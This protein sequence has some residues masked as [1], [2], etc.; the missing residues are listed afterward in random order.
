MRGTLPVA[1]LLA[2]TFL[3][4]NQLVADDPQKDAGTTLIPLL[5]SYARAQIDIT[6]QGNVLSGVSGKIDEV[7]IKTLDAEKCN[8]FL[9]AAQEAYEREG[10]ALLEADLK[11]LEQLEV[12]PEWTEIHA[13][14]MKYI[15]AAIAVEKEAPSFFRSF[16]FEDASVTDSKGRRS[17][18]PPKVTIDANVLLPF[19][20]KQ[21]EF[22]SAAA[23][24]NKQWKQLVQNQDDKLKLPKSWDAYVIR[25]SKA[26]V[27]KKK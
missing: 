26:S 4:T 21:N 12:P 17:L 15:E 7:R 2:S 8:L 16:S 20:Q 10:S 25:V 14:F 24:W 3:L 9:E 19:K 13:T 18:K 27:K 1:L 23:A 6:T 22:I 11:I 5:E